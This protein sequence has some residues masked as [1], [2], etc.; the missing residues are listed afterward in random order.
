MLHTDTDVVWLR[1]PSPYLLCTSEAACPACEFAPASRLPC[2]ALRTADVAVSSDNMGPGLA[3]RG[4]ARY[5]AGGTF[6]SGILL[7]RATP[8]GIRFVRAWH[9]NVAN[10]LPGSRF[11]RLTS[12]QQVRVTVRVRVRPRVSD[13]TLTLTQG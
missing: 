13:L 3:L 11:A 2:D 9:A 5:A 4:G 7:F 8:A 6:N 12:D 1:D 10:P